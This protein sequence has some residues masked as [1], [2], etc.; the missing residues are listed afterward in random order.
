MC[1]PIRSARSDSPR[2]VNHSF[3]ASSISSSAK[4]TFAAQPLARPLPRLGPGDALSA[5]LVAGQLLELAQLGDG[6]GGVE[7]HGATLTRRR[8]YESER[9]SIL[10]ARADASAP[11]FATTT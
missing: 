2:S 3:P 9:G 4:S 7:R 5:V 8:T 6:A 10:S 11:S 1:P